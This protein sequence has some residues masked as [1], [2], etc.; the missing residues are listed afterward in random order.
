MYKW[1]LLLYKIHFVFVYVILVSNNKKLNSQTNFYDLKYFSED[2]EGS[3]AFPNQSKETTLV[4][5]PP[6][7]DRQECSGC[8]WTIHYGAPERKGDVLTDSYGFTYT[9]DR[10]TKTGK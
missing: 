5:P 6:A 2:V 9:R 3:V 10:L 1:Y 8:E 7:T 4:A